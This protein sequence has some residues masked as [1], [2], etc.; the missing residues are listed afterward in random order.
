M[1]KFADDI[2]ISTPASKD[3]TDAT[4]NEVNNMKH[5]ASSNVKE[6]GPQIP[7]PLDKN[8][9]MKKR[10]YEQVSFLISLSLFLCHG[11]FLIICIVKISFVNFKFY[12]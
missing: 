11:I 3:S 1:V 8:W 5:W 4:I 6:K 7:T 10:S 2:T 12:L 9:K